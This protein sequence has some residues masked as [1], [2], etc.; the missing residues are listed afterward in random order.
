M[1]VDMKHDMIL[2]YQTLFSQCARISP[3]TPILSAEAMENYDRR[4]LLLKRLFL[5]LAVCK[6]TFCIE[7]NGAATHAWPFPLASALCHGSRILFRL[8]G[9]DWQEFTNFL[10]LGDS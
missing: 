7:E 6:L 4:V 3:A 5:C 9:V 2:M 1:T 8:D 10:L